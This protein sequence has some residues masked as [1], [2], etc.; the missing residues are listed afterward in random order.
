MSLRIIY[1]RSGS[2]KSYFCMEE[3]RD[4]VKERSQNPLILVVP[5]QYSMQAERN[6]VKSMPSGGAI[7]AEVLSFR[8]MAYRVFGEVGGYTRRHINSSGKSMLIY[9]I[10]EKLKDELSF[11]NKVAGQSGFVGTISE[12]ISE[13]KRYNI[14]PEMFGNLHSDIEDDVLKEKIKEISWIYS[15]FQETIHDRYIDADDDLTLMAEKL[16]ESTQFNGAHI[17]IDEFSGFTPQEYGVIEA[18]LKKADRVNVCLSTDYL[19]DEQAFGRDDVF[20]PI[21][22]T[23]AKLVQ[24]ANGN[25]IRVEKPISFRERP[26]F[27]FRDNDELAHLEEYFFEYP[28][29]R[30]MGKTQDIGIFTASNIYTEIEHVARGIQSLCRE[31][32]IRYR[33]IAVVTRNLEGY[34]RLISAIFPQY[35]IPFFIDKKKEIESHPL[36]TLIL[37]MMDIFV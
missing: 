28:H 18:L 30:Y 32:G 16:E 7:D 36:V 19:F 24:L 27:R 12:L 15:K 13:L 37:S 14:G 23:A 33:D 29:K 20:A 4:R 3:M 11:F 26:F 25:G 31:K 2:G 21:R 35:G 17:W 6:L 5:E 9:G 8:R 22:N 34:D 10:I 1:G